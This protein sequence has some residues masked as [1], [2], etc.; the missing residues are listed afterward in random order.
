MYEETQLNQL[1]VNSSRYRLVSRVF[2]TAIL[3][4]K[5]R[6]STLTTIG[7]VY[8]RPK[9]DPIWSFG[10]MAATASKYSWDFSKFPITIRAGDLNDRQ[11]L[12]GR[13]ILPGEVVLV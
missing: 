7:F 5:K 2:K 11:D 13:Q 10:T 12:K 9:I 3:R 4:I 6:G 8:I 1:I